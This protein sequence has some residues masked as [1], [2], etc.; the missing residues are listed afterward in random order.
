M[1][2][3]IKELIAIGASV[4]T[5]CHPCLKFHLDKARQLGASDKELTIA[6]KV[7]GYVQAGAAEKTGLIAKTEIASFSQHEVADICR[8]D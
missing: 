8:C 3:K 2:E 4:A 1:D 7:G 6:A 5:N